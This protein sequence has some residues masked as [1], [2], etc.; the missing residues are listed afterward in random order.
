MAANDVVLVDGILDDRVAQRL[1]SA[2]RD[3]AFEYFA[4]QQVLRDAELSN[5]EI[6]SGWVDGGDDGGIDGF[7]ILVNGHPVV[8]IDGFAW[9]RSGYEL[10]LWIIT[11]KHHDTFRQ[12]LT[13]LPFMYQV[14]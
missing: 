5:E 6:L 1:P 4:I 9:P 10:E 11:C 13:C 14:E 8:D 12:A 2:Q 7:Y 3:E